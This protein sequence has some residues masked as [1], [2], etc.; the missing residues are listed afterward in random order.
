VA[1][2]VAFLVTEMI[3]LAMNCDPR[4]QIRIAVR[5]AEEPDRAVLRVVSRALIDGEQLI[6]LVGSRYQRV[7]DGLA[8]QLRSRLHH[9]PLIGAYEISFAVLGR[10]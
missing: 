6:A 8:R 4:A 1:V 3:E 7:M 5:A 10:T 2:A 9:D